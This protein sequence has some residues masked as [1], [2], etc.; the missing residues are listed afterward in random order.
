MPARSPHGPRFRRS[1]GGAGFHTPARAAAVA[2]TGGGWG[3]RTARRHNGRPRPRFARQLLAAEHDAQLAGALQH[4]PAPP[5]KKAS[6]RTRSGCCVREAAAPI[7]CAGATR[8]LQPPRQVRPAAPLPRPPAGAGLTSAAAPPMRSGCPEPCAGPSA[9]AVGKAGSAGR[10][11]L[12]RA[13]AAGQARRAAHRR[14]LRC[15]AA[16]ATAW[17]QLLLTLMVRDPPRISTAQ[18]GRRWA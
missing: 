10:R 9:S 6:Q 16:D 3:A 14:T 12:A 13:L 11:A 5:G 1:G 17:R 2:V 4:L 8:L 15:S 18:R 7:S